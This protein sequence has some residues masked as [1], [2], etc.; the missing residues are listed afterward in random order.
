MRRA[1]MQVQR[2]SVTGKGAARSARRAG[3]IPGVIYGKGMDSIPIY[4]DYTAMEKV[5]HESAGSENIL[6]NVG[7]EDQTDITLTL[8]R[9][10][11]HDPLTGEL[12]HLDFL[13]VSI[14]KPLRTTAPLH[15]IGSSKGV[16]EGGIFEMALRDIEIECLPLDIPDYLEIDI[17]EM[18]MGQTLHVYDIPEN[19]KYKILT[20]KDVPVCLIQAPRI[21]TTAAAAAIEG[22]ETEEKA[23]E[24]SEKESE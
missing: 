14:D 4:V 11:Q 21:D 23:E 12:M 17:S 1:D 24:G 7:M 10:T 2:R 8:V 16:K 22:E 3:M 5:F 9:E 19:P 20:D 15:A 13:R 6:V 18:D